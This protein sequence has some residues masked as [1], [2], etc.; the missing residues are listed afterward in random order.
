[1]TSSKVFKSKKKKRIALMNKDR[2][3]FQYN[4]RGLEYI[5]SPLTSQLCMAS[6]KIMIKYVGPIIIYKNYKPT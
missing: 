6:R 4:S 5:I 1:M 2:T 3:F